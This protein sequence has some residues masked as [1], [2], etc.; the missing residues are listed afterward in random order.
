VPELVDIVVACPAV[1]TI[2]VSQV[3]YLMAGLDAEL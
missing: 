1:F 2:L 3:H